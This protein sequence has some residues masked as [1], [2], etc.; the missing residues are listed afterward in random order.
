MTSNPDPANNGLFYLHN[1][2][3]GSVSAMSDENGALVPGSVARYTPFG[4]W[5]AEPS[6]GLTD[7]GFTGHKHN[8]LGSGA[9]NLGLIYMN[10]RYYVGGIGRFDRHNMIDEITYFVNWLRRRNPQART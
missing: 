3:L 2:H 6:A 1:N 9:D 5:R 8:N 10:A 7:R 4:G